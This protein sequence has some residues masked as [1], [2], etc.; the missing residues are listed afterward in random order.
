MNLLQLKHAGHLEKGKE[1][2]ILN[3]FVLGI[4]LHHVC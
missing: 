2:V 4:I 3:S 1:P